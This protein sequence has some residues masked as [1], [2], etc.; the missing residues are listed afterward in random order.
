MDSGQNRIFVKT[1]TLSFD[2]SMGDDINQAITSRSS[3]G[4]EFFCNYNP[5][6]ERKEID[7]FVCPSR[8]T[9]VVQ[10]LGFVGTAM[11]AA[12]VGAEDSLGNP[13]YN[14]IGVDRP[15]K[16]N[17]WK[18]AMVN[19]GR[20]PVRSADVRIGTAYKKAKAMNNIMATGSSYAFSKADVVVVDINIDIKKEEFNKSSDQAFTFESLEE[21]LKTITGQIKRNT[22]VVIE[23]TIPPGTTEKFIKPLFINELK[24]RGFAEGDFDLVYSYERVMP[25]L[26]YLDSII[27]FYRVYAGINQDSSLRARDFFKSF[28]NTSDYPLTELH[29][30][31]AAEM[32]KVLENSY[33]ALNIAFLQEWTEY[34][35]L[36]RVNL[37]QVVEA[38]RMRSTHRNLMMPGF[39]VGG[40]CLTKDPLLADWSYENLYNSTKLLGLSI[41]A[42]EI[43]DYMPDHA[44]DILKELTPSLSERR[45]IIFGVSYLGDV[46]DTRNSPTSRFYDRCKADGAIVTIHDPLVSF[47]PEKGLVVETQKEGIIKNRYDIAVFA[48]RH[49]LYLNMS[50]SNIIEFVSGATIILDANNIISDEVAKEL[51][52]RGMLVVG[53]GKG[54]WNHFKNV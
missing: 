51:V 14:V 37:F 17:F 46:A 18:I 7:L 48:T 20:S 52:S 21:A 15:D 35:K 22:L 3:Y 28:I 31:T 44:F 25:G 38:I 33:R 39:G 40:Y 36:A 11:V 47:W 1:N 34:A 26:S 2:F 23:S 4:E 5:E 50:T 29:S 13:L 6:Q 8:K 53:V 9:V 27:N 43:N 16:D 32:G 10:G 42:V 41:R 49:S 30:P 45:I 24:R 54:H 12:L 19:T